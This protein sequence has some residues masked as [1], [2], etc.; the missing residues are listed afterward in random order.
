V[1]EYL[2]KETSYSHGQRLASVL[3]Q[4]SFHCRRLQY[5][6]QHFND[7]ILPHALFRL[8]MR[9]PHASGMTTLPE[10]ESTILA[11]CAPHQTHLQALQCHLQLPEGYLP[12]FLL[13]LVW[14][15]FYCLILAPA[16]YF[17]SEKIYLLTKYS[18]RYLT[19]G[20]FPLLTNLGYGLVYKVTRAELKR[21]VQAIT[22]TLSNG[23][24]DMIGHL[25][26]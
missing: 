20:P 1:D 5:N 22:Q 25:Q 10:L 4:P 14:W 21:H 8:G 18:A 3:V 2:A 15:D 6:D 26:F 17:D 23:F 12:D 9:Y 7:W 11:I 13:N 24:S 16:I 19:Q